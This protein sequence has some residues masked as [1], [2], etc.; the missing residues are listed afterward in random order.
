[1]QHFIVKC[2]IFRQNQPN[3]I[4]PPPLPIKVTCYFLHKTFSKRHLYSSLLR[5]RLLRL[6]N[7]TCTTKR[8]RTRLR[9]FLCTKLDN[10]LEQQKN[11]HQG[12]KP[13]MP[14][15]LQETSKTKF[16]LSFPIFFYF[17]LVLSSLEASSS[18]SSTSTVASAGASRF[19]QE[20]A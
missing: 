3:I 16:V 1:M 9:M 11:W 18:T 10:T 13:L 14:I 15:F 20:V 17:S 12:F 8:K 19:M 6:S 2:C 5:Q 7:A 4:T